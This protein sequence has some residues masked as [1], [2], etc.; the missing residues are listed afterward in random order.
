[1]ISRERR[2]PDPFLDWKVRI[3]VTG[4]VFLLAYA[5]YMVFLF[6]QGRLGSP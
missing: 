2:G 5:A 6:A 1:M 3:F 4:A